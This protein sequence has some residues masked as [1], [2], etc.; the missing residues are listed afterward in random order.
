MTSSITPMTNSNK[1]KAKIIE[2]GYSVKDVAEK[3]GIQPR[4]LSR[5]IHNKSKFKTS[6]VSELCILLGIT[7]IIEVFFS[8]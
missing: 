7:N 8:A 5:K 4:T 1:L 6:E 2:C 3:I